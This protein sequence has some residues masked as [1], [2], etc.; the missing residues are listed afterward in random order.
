M[1]RERQPLRRNDHFVIETWAFSDRVVID[2]I[3]VDRIVIDRFVARDRCRRVE[4]RAHFVVRGLGEMLVPRTD[5]VEGARCAHCDHR[6]RDL[7]ELVHRFGRGN[8]HRK[9]DPT[10]AVRTSDL[11]RGAA[12]PPVAMPSS[13]MMTVR[14]STDAIG[15]PRRYNEPRLSSSARSRASTA[16]ISSGVTCR[17]ANHLLVEHPRAP[18]PDRTHPQ[19]GLERNPELPDHH[20]VQ[21][22]VKRRATSNATGTPP[23]GSASTTGFS[24]RSPSSLPASATPAS[25]RSRNLRTLVRMGR[26]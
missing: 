25:R 13:T 17:D 8:R 11:H 12:V 14:P 26:G 6:I 21:R 10:C 22:C 16:A 15:R 24:C 4:Q 3:V 2:G 1:T 20:H 18:F 9:N 23:R 5:R 7:G 19:L